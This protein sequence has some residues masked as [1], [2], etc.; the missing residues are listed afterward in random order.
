MGDA[1]QSLEEA[2][3]RRGVERNFR[4]VDEARAV[5]EARGATIAQVALAWLLAQPGVTSP[6]VGPRTLDQLE[7]LLP[8]AALELEAD[9]VERLG[10]HTTP[11]DAYPQR[12]LAEQNG[13][14]VERQ[15]L[16]R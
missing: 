12:F 14:D 8:A 11:P 3:A 15:P 13:I 16:G 5:A 10:R 1:D 4:A 2:P 6:I 7:D 9:E